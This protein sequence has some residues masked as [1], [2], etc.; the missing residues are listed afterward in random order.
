M[1]TETVTEEVV[2][3]TT[4]TAQPDKPKGKTL[5]ELTA[6]NQR[7]ETAL[8]ERNKEEA[9]RRKKLEALEKAEEDR[10][11]AELSETERLKQELAQASAKLEAAQRT[12][13]QRSVS[14]EVGLPA[15]FAT[16]IQGAD[17][18]AMVADAK[19]MLAALPKGTP[20]QPTINP[21]NPGGA[22]KGETD[23]ERRKRLGLR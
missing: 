21:T 18:D 23:D 16:R 3:T 17:R 2:E 6:E 9:A 22:T 11:K 19:A 20:T 1:T 7:L 13:L 4:T 14:D 5:E 12:E 10:K 8:H 15:V